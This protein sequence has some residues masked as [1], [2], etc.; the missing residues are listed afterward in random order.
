MLNE[1]R[2]VTEDELGRAAAADPS[3][4]LPLTAREKR[5]RIVLLVLLSLLLLTLA[6]LT[7]F[8]VRNR[9]MPFPKLE[10]N[11]GAIM[12]PEYLYSITGR[13]KNELKKP[14]G[15]DVANDG[16]VYVVD[17]GNRRVSVFSNRGSYL[18]SFN[19]TPFGVLRNPVHL[20]VEDE[21]VWLT[22]RRIRKLMAFDL[23]GK[24]LRSFDATNEPD[25][26]WTPL[27]FAFDYKGQLRATDVGHT[28][29]H[30]VVYFS[31]EQSRTAAVG[32]TG[33][34]MSVMQSPGSFYFPNGLAIARDG[35]V[36]I[37]DGDNR[38]VQVFDDKGEFKRFINTSGV[39]R[40]LAID[41]K[42]RLF[43]VD[44]LAHTVDIYDLEGKLLTSFGERGFGP[45][46]F[47]FPNDIAIGNDGR[48][49]VTDRENNQVQVWGW[50]QVVIPRTVVPK[51]PWQWMLCLLPLLL[52]PL[53]LLLR[54]KNYVV[55]VEFLTTLA[56]MDRLDVLEKRRL[57]F[58]VPATVEQAV[59]A[60]PAGGR[61]WNRLVV[62]EE[63]SPTDT[64]ALHEKLRCTEEEAIYLTMGDRAKALLSNDVNLRHLGMIARIRVLDVN[65]FL[66][67]S[68]D[69]QITAA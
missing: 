46:Q 67:D 36:Y 26:K 29:K 6:A 32:K 30:R 41:D 17:F 33:Q 63:Y 4:P 13:G 34:V 45:G 19:K 65:E 11:A 69:S 52:L 43:V 47:N 55:T 22:D 64:A 57:R 60:I 59:L 28:K 51:E 27:A 10:P 40:G 1:D 12:P 50:P 7:Y 8:W 58:L 21:E 16:R 35:R 5:R 66:R 62:F 23:E 42:K 20:Q 49:Y 68:D 53:L 31:E 44:A 24:Y 38:R 3:G 25:F 48:M 61:D 56:Q 39:P 37:A 2:L 14:I 15:V 9:T 18:K 54:K